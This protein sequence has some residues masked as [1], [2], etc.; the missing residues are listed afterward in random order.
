MPDLEWMLRGACRDSD[1]ALFH[2][3]DGERGQARAERIAQAQTICASCPA[4]DDCAEYVEAT[5]DKYGTWA[6]EGELERAERWAMEDKG[7][8]PRSRRHGHLVSPTGAYSVIAAWRASGRPIKDLATAAGLD[9]ITIYSLTS[10]PS[11]WIRAG[12]AEAI[13]AV[14]VREMVP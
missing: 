1:P 10:A 5:R 12:T 7:V 9:A 2:H 14:G 13:E 11:R 8:A 3:P 4:F 6:G